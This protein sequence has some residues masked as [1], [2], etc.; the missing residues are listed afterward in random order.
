M[1]AGIVL[2]LPS[3]AVP[4]AA[5]AGTATSSVAESNTSNDSALYVI[6]FMSHSSYSYEDS[7]SYFFINLSITWQYT[8]QMS[9]KAVRRM[10][11]V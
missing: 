11:A 6:L 10:S 1:I 9:T 2:K 5:K 7:I 3:N 8:R 4:L